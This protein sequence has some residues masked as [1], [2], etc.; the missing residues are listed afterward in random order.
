LILSLPTTILLNKNKEIV[1]SH[2]G[3]KPGDE[4]AL[5]VAVETLLSKNNGK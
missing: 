2:T 5:I 4:E 1:Y 3:Y